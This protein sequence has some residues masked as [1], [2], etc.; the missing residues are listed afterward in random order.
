MCIDMIQVVVDSRLDFQ[1][2]AHV[3]IAS[4]CV[5][6]FFLLPCIL[7]V[8]L[9]PHEMSPSAFELVLGLCR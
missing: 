7:S 4:G 1:C 3:M 5:T 8:L 6:V 9:D 2:C